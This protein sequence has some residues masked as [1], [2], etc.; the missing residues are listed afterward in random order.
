[1]FH[2]ADEPG[3]KVDPRWTNHIILWKFCIKHLRHAGLNNVLLNN[4]EWRVLGKETWLCFAF[5]LE[6]I[7][8]TKFEEFSRKS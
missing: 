8:F 6:E 2:K 1:M 5:L 4:K 7:I 3:W